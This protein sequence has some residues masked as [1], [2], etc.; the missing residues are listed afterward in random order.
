MMRLARSAL[1]LLPLVLAASC[2]SSPPAE[3]RGTLASL[4]KVQPD[5]SDVRVEEGLQKA[6]Q[7]YQRFLQETPEG[8]LT[9]EAMRRLADLQ[10]EKEYGVLGDGEIVEVAATSAAGQAA[11]ARA[12]GAAPVQLAAPEATAKVKS[13]AGRKADQAAAAPADLEAE[14]EQRANAG[15]TIASTQAA[16]PEGADPALERA[17]PLEAI[18]LYDELL[19]KYPN[20]AFRDQVLYQKARAYDELGRTTESMEVMQQLVAENPGSKMVDEVQFRRA[21]NFFVRRKYR[22]AENAYAAIANMGAGSEYYELALYKL[23]WSLYKQDMYEEALHRYFALLDHKVSRG[24]D[25]DAQHSPAEERRVEDTFQV[26][27]LSFSN[28]GGPEVIGDYFG[29]HGKRPYEDRVYRYLGEFY[30]G[31]RRYQ[32][33]ATVHGSFVKLYPFHAASPD[34]SMRTIGIYEAGGFPKLVL[35][36]KKSFAASYGRNAEYWRH[37]DITRRPEVLSALK[38]NITD[39]ANHF[40]AQYQDASQAEHKGTNFGEASRWYREYLASFHDDALASAV[41]YQL[42]DLLRE[43]GDHALAAVEYERTAYEYPTHERA[44]AAGYAAI[45][46]HR[47]NLK[48]I[49]TADSAGA[50]RRTVDSSLRF[51]GTFPEHEQAP[52]VLAAAAQDL[53]EL[54]DFAPAREAGRKLIAEFPAASPALRRTGWLVVAH[55]SLELAEYPAAEQAY[56]EVLAATAPADE[57]R[58]DLIDNLAASIYRQGELAN[59]AGD[60]RAA[61]NHFLRIKQ[62]APTAK[63]RAGAE[64]D[65]GAALVRLEDWPGA[66]R[67]LDDFRQSHPQHQLVKDATRQIALAW[68]KAGQLASSAGEY[69]RV[70]AESADPE[71]RAE[72]LLLAGDLYGQS[73]DVE[74]ALAAYTRYVQEFPR[75]VDGAVEARHKMAEIHKA[76]G[77]DL[78]YRQEL[79]QIVSA[80]A[81]AGAERTGRTRTLAARGALVLAESLYTRFAAV[82]LTQPFEKSLEA[83]QQGMDAALAAFDRLVSYEVPDVTTAATFYMAEMYANFSRSLLDSERPAGLAGND[84]RDYE[85]QLDEEAYPFEEKAI[86]LHE[87]NMELMGAGVYDAWTDKSLARLA[88]LMPARYAKAEISSGFLG[89]LDRY[90]YRKP[91]PPAPE[92]AASEAAPV[93]EP[94]DGI[95]SNGVAN[96]SAY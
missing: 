23:G 37:H 48:T 41:N 66:A 6:M 79:E 28:M 20:Y 1:L 46:A 2:A 25:F 27:S 43:N 82:K 74:R 22:D 58:A 32:D 61:A 30:L 8:A 67:V 88:V 47:E 4:R 56:G 92:A 65:A 94:V 72:A 57:S 71:L 55:S 31:K 14:L 64:Y 83:K 86:Q 62:A 15:Q 18:K 11:V 10:V 42:A 68:R 44:A 17:G 13:A 51:A 24:Y 49:G 84:L 78:R 12:V 76:R 29:T 26:T 63:I 7:S 39:L 50:R 80:D 60:F 96:V 53:F 35:D 5:I 54:K 36:S 38:S 33:A 93:T 19:A 9:P 75:P 45:Y 81:A 69:E 77:D 90:E 89:S 59:E 70:A 87:K 91:L 3:R 40:H 34:F 95:A 16:L 52:V 85:D 73:Q 21:E